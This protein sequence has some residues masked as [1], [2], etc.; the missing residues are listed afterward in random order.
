MYIGV[1]LL[2]QVWPITFSGEGFLFF[3]I[4]L[5]LFC[6]PIKRF[7]P[8]TVLLNLDSIGLGSS[9]ALSPV[10]VIVIYMFLP[11][12]NDLKWWLNPDVVA[13]DMF[14]RELV[15]NIVVPHP[16]SRENTFMHSWNRWLVFTSTAIRCT[17]ACTAWLQMDTILERLFI[18]NAL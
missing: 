6:Q 15:S 13:Y 2:S 8:R 12:S 11:H 17:F 1:H 10:L 4:V 5:A 3:T 7:I 16:G 14:F 18:I 9:P